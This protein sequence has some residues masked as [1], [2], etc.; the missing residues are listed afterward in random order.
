MNAFLANTSMQQNDN[1]HS[2]SITLI[3]SSNHQLAPKAI[4]Y[5]IPV[6]IECIY[7]EVSYFMQFYV[8][9]PDLPSFIQLASNVN[10]N[11]HFYRIREEGH[12]FEN[13]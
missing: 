8:I 7:G 11:T 3:K 2:S 6:H 10:R 4:I 12:S 13:R 1:L 9:I 5:E